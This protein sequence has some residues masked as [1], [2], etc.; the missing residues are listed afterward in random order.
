MNFMVDWNEWQYKFLTSDATHRAFFGEFRSGKTMACGSEVFRN[1]EQYP[2]IRI[3]VIRNIHQEL[4]DSTIPQLMDVYDWDILGGQ[5]NRSTRELKLRNGTIIE[6]FALDRLYDTKKLKNVALG[7]LFFDQLEEIAEEIFDMAIGRL[8][9]RHAPNRSIAAGNFE[10]KGWYWDRFFMNPVESGTGVFKGK[11]R[12]YG[13]YR[14]R[15]KNFVGFWPPPF[16]NEKNLPPEYYDTQIASHPPSWNDKYMYGIP[17]GNAGLLHKE[18]NE[19]R[20]IIRANDYFIPPNNLGWVKYES[21][22]H[23]IA[24]PT[25]WLFVV[26]DRASDTIY[27]IDE[28][29]EVQKNV[30]E[31]GPNILKLRQIHGRPNLTL[32][33][34][35]TFGREKDGRTVSDVYRESFQIVLTPHGAG[36]DARIDV[37]NRRFS[38]G[39]IKIFERCVNLKAQLEHVSW[40]NYMD[41]ED[42]ALE[43]FQR[44]VDMIDRNVSQVSLAS[45]EKKKAEKEAREAKPDVPLEL[46]K[47][48]TGRGRRKTTGNV[49]KRDF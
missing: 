29:Y 16:L 40:K 5:L 9:Q 31:H 35:S 15:N 25:C 19:S 21:M 17:V 48:R 28:Y 39:K 45:L 34:P 11:Q 38:L 32:G 8:S 42:H 6:F 1:A 33:C 10:G 18:F 46:E 12:D 27:F 14:G 7:F 43:P 3:G 30:Y 4:V 13:I 44:I 20:H 26:Y 49:L 36:I 2:G 22:D 41:A 47:D 24:T 37:V 23:G